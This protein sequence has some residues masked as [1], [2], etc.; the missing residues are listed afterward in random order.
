MRDVPVGATAARDAVPVMVDDA[1][2]SDD[3][4]SGVRGVLAV[5]SA[6]GVDGDVHW[7]KTVGRIAGDPEELRR[8]VASEFFGRHIDRYSKSRRRAP[9][10]WQLG[11]PSAAYSVWLYYHSFTRDTFYSV[12]NDYVSPKLQHEER[13]LMSLSREAGNN[14]SAGQR[15][16]ID[17]QAQFVG[18]LRAF[19]EE[20]G[21]VA[22][23]WNPDLNDGVIINFAPLWRLVPQHRAW[24]KECKAN[25]D[26]LCKG[27]Y[28]WAHLAMHLWPERVVPKCTKDRSL[29]IAHGIDD[30]FWSEDSEGK[31]QPRN[32]PQADIDSLVKERTSAAA[33]DALKSLLGA[34]APTTT[35]ASKKRTPRATG[36]R[37]ETAS[38]RPTSA[39]DGSS[40]RSGGWHSEADA[41]LLSKVKDAIA[42]NSDGASKA[43]VIDATGITS[44]QWNTAIKPLL[45]DGSV[46]RTGKRRGARYHLAGGD[47]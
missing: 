18:E 19:R 2:H 40:S 43:D 27:D 15:E 10:Y 7:P 21:R 26:K 39:T 9:I 8:W 16:E 29:A 24:Q 20:I 13:R 46:A 25:W 23:L 35:K 42:A 38:T 30:V 14:P 1:G 45:A 33:K 28:D 37:R 12:L 47:A 22:P 34:P 4:L 5:A 11:A 31:W 6:P 17:V 36:T 44:G 3:L 32:V 41:D